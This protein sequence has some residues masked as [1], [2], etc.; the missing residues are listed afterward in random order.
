MK[1]AILYS[2]YFLL[3][4]AVF[5]YALFPGKTVKSL[6]EAGAARSLPGVDFMVEKVK[7]SLPFSV[8]LVGVRAAKGGEKLF[9]AE[10]VRVTPH[11]LRFLTGGWGFSAVTRAYGGRIEVSAD[12]KKRLA[13]SPLSAKIGL[14]EVETK[15]FGLLNRSFGFPVSGTLSTDIVFSGPA[16]DWTKGE[17]SAKL[18]LSAGKLLF[19]PEVVGPAGLSVESLSAEFLLQKE[20]LSFKRFEL[21][22][23]EAGATLS[24]SIF[25]KRPLEASRLNLEGRL[26]PTPA[27]FRRLGSRSAA[28][29]FLKTKEGSSGG[30]GF[31][32]S[33]TAGDEQVGFK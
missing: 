31:T 29:V 25:L 12:G 22:G 1:K 28:A 19:M 26:S 7:P 2:V 15:D 30:L 11:I 16:T 14:S 5:L 24:G 32:L 33:G 9:S 18:A 20:E 3:A 8:R 4:A 10:S 6:I 27:F 13:A 21:S 23:P 17:G